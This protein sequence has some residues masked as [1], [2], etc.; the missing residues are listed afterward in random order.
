MSQNAK[1]L[2]IEILKQQQQT[3]AAAYSNDEFYELF[4]AEQILKDYDLSYD[5][6]EAGITDDGGDGG[7]DSAYLFLN[8]DLVQSDPT[9]V[10]TA[11]KPEIELVIIQSKTS[12]SFSEGAIDKLQASASDLF[13]LETTLVSLRSVYNQAVLATFQRFRD[14]Y[15]SHAAKFPVLRLSYYYATKG[16]QPDPKVKRK[17]EKLKREIVRLFQ[18]AQVSF[19]FLGARELLDLF[20]KQRSSTFTIKLAENA[21]STGKE[22]YICLVKLKE[23]YRFISD[24][25]GKVRRGLFEANVR[26]YQGKTEV[27]EQIQAT[28]SHP[29]EE[30]FWWLNNGITVLAKQ[31]TVSGKDL[32]VEEPQI[33]NGLQTSTE[34]HHYFNLSPGASDKRHLLVRILNT[35]SEASR[36][37]V[38]KATNSQTSM[39]AASLRATEK[40]HR[41][42]EDYFKARG[43][44]YDRRKNFYKN[45]GKP[46]AQIVS[47]PYAAQAVLAVALQEPDNARARPS[48]LLKNDNDHARIFNP[49]H[50]LDLFLKCCL[51]VRKVEGFLK[52]HSPE[53]DAN[54][55]N[56][57]RFYIA[58][59]AA[60]NHCKVPKPCFDHLAALDPNQFTPEVLEISLKRVKRIYER[61]G[62]DDQVA[63]GAVL[64]QRLK[65]GFLRSFKQTQIS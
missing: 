64:L 53:L 22:A 33:V 39:P 48:S 25:T 63:K 13:D 43:L 65:S 54:T 6:L 44:F 52:N 32:R 62:A 15:T 40:I 5:E 12:D 42:I 14:L 61:L 37:R 1:I 9:P 51:L 34:I 47:I 24:G 58:M 23:F 10:S 56:N 41:D 60:V 18:D 59:D 21:I 35:D 19:T 30:D 27:N 2:L 57:L 17:V 55:R 7:I 38:I 3:L 49:Q 50:P 16:T 26:D 11:K 28:L 4:T 31:A 36:D 45:L 20:R 46:I 8:G 29:A